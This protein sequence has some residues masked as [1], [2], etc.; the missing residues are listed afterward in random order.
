MINNN[1]ACL[2]DKGDGLVTHGMRIANVCLDHVAKWL[3]HAGSQ[4]LVT[5]KVNSKLKT[6]MHPPK[7][8]TSFSKI[9][10]E[11]MTS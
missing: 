9:N 3:L 5:N 11:I 6:T 1:L 10:L 4:L 8:F 7:T 2:P